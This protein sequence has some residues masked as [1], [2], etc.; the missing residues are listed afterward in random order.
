MITV[1]EINDIDR[2]AE[3]RL[4]WKAMWQRTRGASFF[5]SLE[6]LEQY[7]RSFGKGKKLRVLIVSVAGRPIG[8]VPLIVKSVASGVGTVRVLTYPL[9][10]WGSH[11]GQIGPHPAATLLAAMRHVREA[12]RDWDLIDLRYVDRDGIDRGRTRNAMRACGL[13][14]IERRWQRTTIVELNTSWREYW[15]SRSPSLRSSFYDAERQLEATGKVTYQRHRPAGAAHAETDPRWDLYSAFERLTH[16]HR[17]ERWNRAGN[18][19]ALRFLRRAHRAAVQTGAADLNLLFID[20]E[21]VAGIYNYQHDGHLQNV[22]IKLHRDVSPAAGV[23]LIGRMI[24]DGF[25]RGDRS[26]TFSQPVFKAV[27]GWQTSL[28]TSARYTHFARTEPRAQMLRLNC[29]MANRKAETKRGRTNST[30]SLPH[31]AHSG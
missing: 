3:F 21:P 7:W 17:G 14:C 31:S 15:T 18:E 8:I 11:Y 27:Q 23:V 4:L 12:R 19:N 16:D 30:P 9:D 25:E 24:G 22:A 6:W 1:S 28:S 20:G 29:F 13:G 5:Q 2:L 10:S 26:H